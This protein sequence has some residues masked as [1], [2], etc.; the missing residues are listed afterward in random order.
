VRYWSFRYRLGDEELVIREGLLTRN[1]RHV[2]YHRIQNVDLVQNPLHRLLG[3]AEVRLETAGGQKPEATLRV[4]SLDAVECM[5]ERVF[6]E[7]GRA[8]GPEAPEAHAPE[9]PRL[10]HHMPPTEVLRFGI[11]SNQGMVVVAAALGL[12]WQLDVTERFFGRLSEKTFQS[13]PR[14][15][16]AISPVVVALAVVFA[17]V[18][19]VVLLR[20]LSVCW[21][22]L[23]LYDFRLTR[24][25]DDLRASYGLLTR[26]SKT[27]PRHRIQ[28]VS[29]RE[30][31]LHRRFRRAAIQVETA[32]SAHEENSPVAGR[33][34]LAPLIPAERVPALV[35][36]ALP[37][38]DLRAV[39]WKPLAARTGRRLVVR[40][41]TIAAI[42]ATVGAVAYPVWGGLVLLGLLPLA[43]LHARLY[44]RHAGWALHEEFVLYR[45]GWWN[46]RLAVARFGKIQAVELQTSP[47]DRRH[48][49]ATVRVDTAGA[50][51]AGHGIAVAFLEA[52]TA[53]G[54][55]ERLAAE[56]GRAAFRW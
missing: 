44:V 17:V 29:V 20:V 22:F 16:P 43:W 27:I 55:K 4:L 2:P 34:W 18:A 42:A 26:V 14:S 48:G 41:V 53:A 38:L 46:R 11:I 3:V 28:L 24:G 5:R 45:S 35:G 51:R 19:F 15:F 12:L 13:L 21:A 6:A 30:G 56:A 8:R 32:G 23:K 1:E 52:A 47:F 39:E 25:G 50:G 10:L 36:E 7:R 49:M 40:G 37:G 31:F 9:S 54:L 33:S